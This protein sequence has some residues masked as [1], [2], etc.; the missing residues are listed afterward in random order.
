[1][2]LFSFRARDDFMSC[3]ELPNAARSSR[4]ARTKQLY[5]PLLHEEGI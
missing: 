5:H 2:F 1:M 4:I 3:I